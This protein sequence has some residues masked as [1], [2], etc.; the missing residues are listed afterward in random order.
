MYIDRIR[1]GIKIPLFSNLNTISHWKERSADSD[2]ISS[3]APPIMGYLCLF[4]ASLNNQG[5]LNV[6]GNV[7]PVL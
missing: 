7:Q 1:K 5:Y 2:V 3:G 4:I 6:F